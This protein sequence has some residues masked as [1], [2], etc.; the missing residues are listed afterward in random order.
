[1]DVSNRYPVGFFVGK[2]HLG[3]GSQRSLSGVFDDSLGV[4]RGGL[5]APLVC[6][7]AKASKKAFVLGTT[8]HFMV[9]SRN[10]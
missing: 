5:K 6:K 4:I 7:Q 3:G 8:I 1:M 10:L 2:L 9:V